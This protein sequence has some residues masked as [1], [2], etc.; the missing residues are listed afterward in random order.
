[1]RPGLTGLAQVSGRNK[2]SWDEKFKDDIRYV[3]K[4]TYAG[5]LKIILDTIRIVLKREG[6]NNKNAATMT[7]FKG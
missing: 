7:E 3:S 2:L 1:M 5:D 6:I 4:I